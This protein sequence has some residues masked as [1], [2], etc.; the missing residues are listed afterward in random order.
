MTLATTFSTR[1]SAGAQGQPRTWWGVAALSRKLAGAVAWNSSAGISPI[2][3]SVIFDLPQVTGQ[4]L[5]CLLPTAHCDL[6][7]P[8]PTLHQA[9][10]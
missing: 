2:C 8:Q 9:H 7:V 10:A 4:R 1:T 5:L 6:E 3:L